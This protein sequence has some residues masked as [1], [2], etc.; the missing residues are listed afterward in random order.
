MISLRV[1][2]PHEY[3]WTTI[4][5]DG[6]DEEAAAHVLCASLLR[7]EW[8]IQV[9]QDGGEFYELGEDEEPT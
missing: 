9:S 6:E 2:S 1:C 4:F 8:T 3:E 7:M 5:F